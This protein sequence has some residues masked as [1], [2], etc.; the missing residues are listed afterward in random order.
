MD[1]AVQ[2]MIFPFN[3]YNNKQ[4]SIFFFLIFKFYFMKP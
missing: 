4:V 3:H 2:D 1:L